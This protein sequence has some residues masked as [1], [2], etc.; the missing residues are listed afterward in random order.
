MQVRVVLGERERGA[1]IE[2]IARV[3]MQLSWVAQ[4]QFAQSIAQ[5]EL[6]LPQFLTLAF[7]VKAQQHCSM[8]QLAEATHQDAATMTGVVDRLERLRLVERTRSLED[9]R[10][11]LVWPTP[12][13]LRLLAAVKETRDEM[14]VR[15]FAAFDDVML[16]QLDEQLEHLWRT[17]EAQHVAT[18]ATTVK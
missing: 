14:M 11:V 16:L 18:T 4:K 15:L 12:K 17:L 10:V 3:L 13:G 2:N 6:T 1:H 5:Y 9:R 7:L 8:N